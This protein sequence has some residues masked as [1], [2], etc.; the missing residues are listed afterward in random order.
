MNGPSTMQTDNR[1]PTGKAIVRRF[2]EE[3]IN[4]GRLDVVDDVLAAS[5]PSLLPG[6]DG[7]DS[8]RQV[9]TVYR[10]AVPDVHWRIEE[11][12]EEGQTVVTCFVACGTQQGPLWGMPATGRRMAVSGILISHCRD[13]QIVS[14]H[15]QLDLLG[16]LQQ[17][18]LMPD[19]ALEEVVT[20]A[21]VARAGVLLAREPAPHHTT[22]SDA[23]APDRYT[24]STAVQPQA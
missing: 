21:Q 6:S 8:V 15:M 19:L 16:L 3:A 4:R 7:P 11:Q 12:V 14:Q 10:S 18:G 2:V 24:D 13:G 9:L 20:V 23:D 1:H 17:L 5:F 22:I